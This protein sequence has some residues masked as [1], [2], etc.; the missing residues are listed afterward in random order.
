MNLQEFEKALEEDDFAVGDSFWTGNWEF[1]VVNSRIP[2]MDVWNDQVVFRWELTRGDFVRLIAD[3]PLPSGQK[4]R[5]C[6]EFKGILKV[7]LNNAENE[8]A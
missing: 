6:D 3:S 1:E 4:L 8:G 5:K 2:G 7:M